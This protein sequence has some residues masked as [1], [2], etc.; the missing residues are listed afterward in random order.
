M[1]S[2]GCRRI[3]FLARRHSA[4]TV[5]LRVF[6]YHEALFSA[7]LPCKVESIHYGNPEDKDFLKQWFET[8][9]PDA[10]ICANDATAATLMHTLDGM[11]IHVPNDVCVAGFDD[12]RYSH[13]L[14]VPLTTV[15]QPCRNIGTVALN[16]LLERIKNP[17]MEAREILIEAP[18]VVRQSTKRE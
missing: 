4:P 6:G 10:I 11:G 7:G 18:I 1:L 17:G 15:S 16:A 5:A 3:D 14:R 8:R 9:K 12:V 13:L 2:M